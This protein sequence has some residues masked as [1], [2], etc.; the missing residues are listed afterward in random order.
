MTGQKFPKHI[1]GIF[2]KLLLLKVSLQGSHYSPKLLPMLPEWSLSG[3]TK[4]DSFF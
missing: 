4:D 2:L 1:F 3:V